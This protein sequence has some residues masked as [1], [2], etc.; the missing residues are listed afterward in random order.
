MSV[1]PQLTIRT[2]E[3]LERLSAAGHRCELVEGVLRPMSPANGKHGGVGMRL[4][5]GVS[6]Y[7]E[8][9]ELGNVFLAETGFLLSRNPDTV[10][11]PDWAFV[12]FE[13]LRELP[14]KGYITVVPDLV[15][16]VRSPNDRPVEVRNKVER[17]L[18]YGV[19]MVWQ[20]DP[21]SRTLVVHQPGRSPRTL[22]AQDTLFG[23]EIL[24]GWSSPLARIF[25]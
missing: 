1:A 9:H 25:R 7:I 13:R 16:E 14:E 2:A 3:E 21:M 6:H 8:E 11:A 12:A 22:T 17:W 20:C 15:L 18:A 5:V 4:A 23:D 10:L 19:R 24:P